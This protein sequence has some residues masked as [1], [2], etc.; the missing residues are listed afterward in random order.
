MEKEMFPSTA[1]RICL[2]I[3]KSEFSIF[4]YTEGFGGFSAR[5]IQRHCRKKSGVRHD[6]NGSWQGTLGRN[7]G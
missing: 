3:R 2:E 6:A 1:R 5:D 4:R 7:M